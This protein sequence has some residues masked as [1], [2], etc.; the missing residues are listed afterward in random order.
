V[1]TTRP[2]PP[3][4]AR[5]APSPLDDAIARSLDLQPRTRDLYRECVADFLA[6]AGTDPRGWTYGAVE[7]WLNRL[8]TDGRTVASR[9]RGKCSPQTVRVY[10]KAV[11]FA[12]R[13]YARRS[14][15]EQFDFARSVGKVKAKPS[16]PRDPLT[17]EEADALLETCRNYT[18][19][20]IRDRALLVLALRSGLRRGGLCAL[21]IEGIRP[22]KITTT[23]KGGDP[24][25]FEADGET[26]SVL[27]EWLTLLRAAG[28][29][30]GPV[31]R[32]VGFAADGQTTVGEPLTPYQIWSVFRSRAK[33]AKIRH[34]FPHLARHST[35]TWLREEGKSAA[36]VGKLTGQSE[37][38]IEN[39]YTHVRTRGAVGDA[40]PSLLKGKK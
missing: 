24:I 13:Q 6:F 26:F 11:R 36:E 34:V 22:P 37:R 23:N 5:S 2:Q 4:A 17:Y 16:A 38:T 39:I 18:P 10:R 9:D 30:S 29:T 21:V 40:M 32:A 8:L 15:N 1:S 3:P 31:F 28:V 20:N 7:D 19:I 25:T 33:R 12:S 27:D 14:G 35:V